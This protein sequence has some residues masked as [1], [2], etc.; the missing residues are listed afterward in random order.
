MRAVR[1]GV[2]YASCNESAL[3]RARTEEAPLVA[4]I[5]ISSC[6]AGRKSTPRG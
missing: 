5:E 3:C 2:P 4:K 6:R 1:E